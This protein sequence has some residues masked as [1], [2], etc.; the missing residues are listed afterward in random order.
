[1]NINSFRSDLADELIEEINKDDYKV[2]NRK[3]KDVYISKVEIL[4]DDNSLNKK[5]GEYVSINF[6]NV[7]EQKNRDVI[8]EVLADSLSKLIDKYGIKEEDKVLVI[9]LGNED[10]TADAL[11]PMAAKEV[12]V[13][14]H[15]FSIEGYPIKKGTKPVSLLT[16]GVMG[17]TGL[18]TSE[19]IKGVI[20]KIKEDY[21][22]IKV[23]QV[24]AYEYNNVL[25]VHRIINIINDKGEYYFYTK[26]DSNNNKDNY[27]RIYILPI[28]ECTIRDCLF[29]SCKHFT[30]IIFIKLFYFT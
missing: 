2:E 13:T 25:V 30:I 24:L 18:E 1:M 21:S 14:S 16:P 8:K 29:Y 5:V 3:Y 23:D 19:I 26:G 27:C 28:Y 10:F 7:E 15:L 12:V 11:G 22:K 9:G 6:N 17:Q 4:K 20:D